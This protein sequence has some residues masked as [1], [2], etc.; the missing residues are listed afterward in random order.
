MRSKLTMKRLFSLRNLVLAS[1]FLAGAGL[2]VDGLWIKGKAAIA[3][4]MLNQAFLS[5][6]K[7]P[8]KPW[9]WADI[10]PIA[11]ISAPRLKQSN[12]VLDA[13]SGEALAFGPGHLPGTPMPGERGTTVFSAHRDTHFA[14]LGE[15]KN[16]DR[17][18]VEKRDGT[19]IHYKIR[20]AWIARFDAP[21][22]N[23][24]SDEHLIALTTCWPLDANARGPLRYVVEGVETGH[25]PAHRMPGV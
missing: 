14:W 11:K 12:V 18:T 9:P 1:V 2:V 3:Q 21:G 7:A 22:I 24:D 16:G 10:R 19:K 15:L 13:T 17:V 25:E 20:R 5:P 23:A 4:I 8:Q 6:A